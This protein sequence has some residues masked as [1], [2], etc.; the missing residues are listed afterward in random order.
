[1]FRPLGKL[2]IAIIVLMFVCHAALAQGHAARPYEKM[3]W[4]HI[5]SWGIN[6]ENFDESYILDRSILGDWVNSDRAG[7]YRENRRKQVRAAIDAGLDGFNIDFVNTPDAKLEY[8]DAIR[9]YLAAA[10]G[11]PFY[12]APCLD[13]PIGPYAGEALRRYMERYGDHP[14]TY[15]VNGRPVIFIYSGISDEDLA[16]MIREADS[17]Q[18]KGFWLMQ[19]RPHIH[20]RE[21]I[22][23]TLKL[24]DGM[25]DFGMTGM[26][27]K[28]LLDWGAMYRELSDAEGKRKL[29]CA[30]ACIGYAGSINPFYRPYLNTRTLRETF[31]AAVE[32]DADWISVSTWNDYWEHTQ[33]EPSF[34]NRDGWGRITR[35]LIREWKGQP[36]P[37]RPAEWVAIYHHEVCL[38]DD[39]TFELFSFPYTYRDT[40]VKLRLLDLAGKVV[41]EFGPLKLGRAELAT[42]TFRLDTTDLALPGLQPMIGQ[43]E[44]PDIPD[45]AYRR[46][47]WI[48][49][50]VNTMNSLRT[51]L[52]PSVQLRRDLPMLLVND[53]PLSN[54][55]V[56]GGTLRMKVGY[57]DPANGGSPIARVTIFRNNHPI[58]TEYPDQQGSGYWWSPNFHEVPGDNVGYPVDIYTACLEGPDG[59]VAWTQPAVVQ[60]PSADV[61]PVEVTVFRTGSD[62]DE[63]WMNGSRLEKPEVV[64]RTVRKCDVPTHVWKLDEG[65]GDRCRDTGS[66]DRSGWLGQ[67][68]VYPHREDARKPAW[69]ITD[70]PSGQRPVLAFDGQDDHVWLGFRA[71]PFGP[72]T[73]LLLARPQEIGRQQTLFSDMLRKCEIT[74]L[75]DGHV[76]VG[77]YGRKADGEKI[78]YLTSTGSSKLTPDQWHH[79]AAVHDG[80]HLRLYVNGQEDASIRV[81]YDLTRINSLGVLGCAVRHYI[82]YHDHFHGQLAGAALTGRTLS[83][84]DIRALAAA[85]A[86]T[87]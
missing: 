40:Y 54:P 78:E 61:T 37:P 79:L 55:G 53:P 69:Q 30:S 50:R 87:P 20:S 44:S 68:A 45:I 23:T 10:E 17:G 65:E 52:V 31:Q 7:W 18:W 81:G 13:G 2:Y 43:A 72:V 47:P 49:L 6:P 12:M 21:Q 86:I 85:H 26:Q 9:E 80:M 75:P 32:T 63:A 77:A 35:E 3:A 1:M 56:A 60:H 16:A 41:K 4:A 71:M 82:T 38:G 57:P 34:W 73:V 11:L 22:S 74:L 42:N 76:Q 66:W 46:L 62:F 48:T 25:Y 67:M 64:T 29:V 19:P 70:T 33:I 15:R 84:E 59:A 28:T 39:L 36:V 24:V 83:T 27:Y 5:V 58:I 14:N 51:L 8:A